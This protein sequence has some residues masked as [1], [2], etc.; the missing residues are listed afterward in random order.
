VTG[1]EHGPSEAVPIFVPLAL[2]ELEAL[3]VLAACRAVRDSAPHSIAGSPLV[4]AMDKLAQAIS[5]ARLERRAESS[6]P[7]REGAE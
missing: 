5:M 1:R 7:D 3:G 2:S 6:S 4:T